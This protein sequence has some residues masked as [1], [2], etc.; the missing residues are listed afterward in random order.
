MQLFPLRTKAD[1][2][3]HYALF[4]RFQRPDRLGR[5]AEQPQELLPPNSAQPSDG[6]HRRVGVRQILAGLR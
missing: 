2:A 5:A 4:P 1:R 6:D 3:K